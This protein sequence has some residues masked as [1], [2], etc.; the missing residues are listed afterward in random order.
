MERT[1][2]FIIEDNPTLWKLADNCA[3][4]WN[5]VNFGR[6]QAYTRYKKFSWHPKHLYKKYAPLVGSATAQQVI[7]KNNEAW[8]SFF[9]LKRL[10]AKG[11]LPSHIEKVSMPRYWKR[12][13]RRELRII[14]R[15]DCYKV[16]DEHLHLPKGLRVRWKGCLK[17]R[18]KQGRLGDNL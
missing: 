17:W 16:D 12:N 2:T 8:R 14:I 4:L 9:G 18:G 6:R 3:R 10:E 7:R 5:E 1:N 15:K 13:G 11:K